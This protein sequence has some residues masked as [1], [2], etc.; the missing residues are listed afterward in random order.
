M[1][2]ASGSKGRIKTLKWTLKPIG[3]SGAPAVTFET[4]ERKLELVLLEDVQVDLEVSDGR[5]RA[6]ASRT[7]KVIP[8]QWKTTFIQEPKDG[9][10]EGQKTGRP[11]KQVRS[12]RLRVRRR[13][14]SSRIARNPSREVERRCERGLSRLRDR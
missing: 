3:S 1:L 11:G 14:C 7:A 2:D 4:T 10:L 6:S 9:I 13:G 12:G 5:T 8:R